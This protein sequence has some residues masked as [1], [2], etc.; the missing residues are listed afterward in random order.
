MRLLGRATYATNI[1]LS[2][3]D[4]VDDP[5]A[6]FERSVR[7]LQGFLE[8]GKLIPPMT[9][10]LKQILESYKGVAAGTAG[11]TSD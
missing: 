5:K 1:A 7:D 9:R 10:N 4:D 2:N 3:Y 11:A 8:Q 6:L